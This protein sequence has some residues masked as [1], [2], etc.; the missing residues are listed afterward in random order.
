MTTQEFSN[1]FDVLYNNITSNQAPGLDEYEKSIFLTKAQYELVKNY[2]TPIQGG[3]KYQQGFDDSHKRQID[4]SGLI[5]QYVGL[6][7][8]SDKLSKTNVGNIPQL[9]GFAAQFSS[10]SIYSSAP[11]G[12]LIN[13]DIS[14]AIYDEH[15][16]G[17]AREAHSTSLKD[18]MLIVSERVE[19][20]EDNKSIFYQVVPIKLSELISKLSKPYGR[21]LKKQIWRVIETF[22]DK[23]TDSEDFGRSMFR[24][25]F[26]DIDKKYLELGTIDF[27]QLPNLDSLLID[28]VPRVV[29]YMTYIKRPAPIILTDLTNSGLSID[30]ISTV[31]ECLLD[32]EIHPEILQRAVELAKNAYEGALNNAVELG[33]RAE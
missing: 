13:N 27:N 17:D 1:E 7:L 25:I 6:I 18:L 24:F 14:L 33:K 8:S 9:S 10:P 12:L 28:S 2:F 4:F 32:P 29:Y 3:N 31:S 21:P 30:G 16:R 11:E 26:H 5:K 20:R 22:S 19:L 23:D 15:N